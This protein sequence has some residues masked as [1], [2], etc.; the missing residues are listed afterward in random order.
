[1]RSNAARSPLATAAINQTS[2]C[3]LSITPR[4]PGQYAD[5]RYR[6][7]VRRV[8]ARAGGRLSARRKD[9]PSEPARARL[10]VRNGL[11]KS[12]GLCH[13]AARP[14]HPDRVEIILLARI[15]L[16]ALARLIALVEQL[17]LL[18]LLERL[19]EC[20]LGIVELD[21][22]LVGRTLEIFLP[23]HRGL[24]VRRIREM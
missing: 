7:G 4:I 21:L 11:T 3:E 9:A 16:G 12:C 19:A 8:R 23:L 1:S 22:E 20:R 18:E 13:R 17:H 5:Y 15:L 14:Q 2:S 10:E 24:G 6:R